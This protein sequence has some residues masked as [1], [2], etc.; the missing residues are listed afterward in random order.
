MATANSTNRRP[1]TVL[2]SVPAETRLEALSAV[3][4][5]W[6]KALHYRPDPRPA[7]PQARIRAVLREVRT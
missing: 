5:P 1:G 2:L 7:A 3:L 4:A 6:G